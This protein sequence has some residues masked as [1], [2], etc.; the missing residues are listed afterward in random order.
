[1]KIR[2]KDYRGSVVTGW[3]VPKTERQTG[4]A[5]IRL[6]RFYLRCKQHNLLTR[7]IVSIIKTFTEKLLQYTSTMG[8]IIKYPEVIP[9]VREIQNLKTEDLKEELVMEKMRLHQPATCSLCRCQLV[10]PAYIVYRKETE[11]VKQ[12]SPVGVKCLHHIA[13]KLNNLI[14]EMTIETDTTTVATA[15]ETDIPVA[16]SA[17]VSKYTTLRLF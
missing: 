17:P 7:N 11:V 13:G 5:F 6:V 2:I 3:K 1:M 15:A 16:V 14:T 4:W 8:W 10:Y 9:L 12:S